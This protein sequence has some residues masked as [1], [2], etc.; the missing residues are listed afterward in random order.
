MTERRIV[1]AESLNTADR[2]SVHELRV[3]VAH[4]FRRIVSVAEGQGMSCTQPMA[5]F[6]KYS[7]PRGTGR[8]FAEGPA[9]DQS[10]GIPQDAEMIFRLRD[11]ASWGEQQAHAAL[12]LAEKVRDG[13]ATAQDASEELALL[14]DS[15]GVLEHRAEV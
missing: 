3:R 1:S 9:E 4:V 15:L 2:T 14:A 7:T 8:V 13:V 12:K 6:V 11:A 5:A 10:S